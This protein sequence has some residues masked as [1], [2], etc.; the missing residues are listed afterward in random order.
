MRF[1]RICCAALRAWKLSQVLRRGIGGKWK[2]CLMTYDGNSICVLTQKNQTEKESTTK[3]SAADAGAPQKKHPRL[4]CYRP[5][6][7]IRRPYTNVVLKPIS[8]RESVCFQGRLLRGVA[9]RPYMGCSQS[10]VPCAH[11]R[12]TL[13]LQT[14]YV[15]FLSRSTRITLRSSQATITQTVRGPNNCS[16]PPKP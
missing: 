10:G 11:P 1:R 3:N 9:L 4:P 2:G 16:S 13:G 5:S 8:R 6:S 12:D 7:S 15:R 14:C